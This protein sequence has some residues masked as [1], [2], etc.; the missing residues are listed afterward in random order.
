VVAL[1]FVWHNGMAIYLA[2]TETS[3]EFK[4]IHDMICIASVNFLRRDNL[5][6][7]KRKSRSDGS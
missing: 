1:P 5:A 2:K 4:L 6:R 3:Q 7:L